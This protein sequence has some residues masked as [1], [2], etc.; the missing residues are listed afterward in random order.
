MLLAVAAYLA[1][2]DA[3]LLD[4]FCD[5][6]RET[7]SQ[8]LRRFSF[9]FPCLFT[10]TDIF[11]HKYCHVLSVC[12]TC[13]CSCRARP[14]WKNS[15]NGGAVGGSEAVT[16]PGEQGEIL[17]LQHTEERRKVKGMSG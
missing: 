9:L 17:T 1:L 6:K 14:L 5:H 10:L 13:M 4:M 12:T 15:V 16:P 7:G 2:F 11:L 3:K 8:N